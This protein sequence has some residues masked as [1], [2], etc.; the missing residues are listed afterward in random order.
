MAEKVFVATERER[1]L[2]EHVVS[3][4]RSGIVN[5]RSRPATDQSWDEVGGHQAP[6]L[7]V[8]RSRS[9]GGVPAIGEGA[10]AGTSAD[11][12]PGHAVCDIFRIDH[13]TVSADPGLS[14]V[15]LSQRVYNV[16]ST[17][18]TGYFPVGRDKFGRWIALV[19]GGGGGGEN[20]SFRIEKYLDGGVYLENN[21]ED[22]GGEFENYRA[23]LATPLSKSCNSTVHYYDKIDEEILVVDRLG[24]FFDEPNVILLPDPSTG[25]QGR[26]GYATYMETHN[27]NGGAG[28]GTAGT[29]VGTGTLGGFML[30]GCYYEVIALCCPPPVF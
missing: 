18:P 9:A 8:A 29:G 7:Y 27:P 3:V 14:R 21:R 1:Q 28:T 25:R 26:K 5:A 15:G 4:V 6:E 13:D 30:T 23:F 10:S 2:L 20:I 22:E 16:S 11:D 17:A 24:C 19:P 12:V